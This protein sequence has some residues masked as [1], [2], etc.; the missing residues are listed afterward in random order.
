[1]HALSLCFISAACFSAFNAAHVAVDLHC[2]PVIQNC[3]PENSE[4][5]TILVCALFLAMLLYSNMHNSMF[6]FAQVG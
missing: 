6:Y 4:F 3:S 1:M 5:L 2:K